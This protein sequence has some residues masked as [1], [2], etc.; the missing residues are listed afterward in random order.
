MPRIRKVKFVWGSTAR[1][2][3]YRSLG[4]WLVDAR[5][6]DARIKGVVV[7]V[8]ALL[9]WAVALVAVVYVAGTMQWYAIQ[10]RRVHCSVTRADALLL[11]LRWAQ[12]REK[13]GRDMIAQG[14]DDL[15]AHRW[16]E[17]Q[18]ELRTGLARA[19]HDPRARLELAQIYVIS[20][21]RP[22]ALTLLTEDLA[23]GYPG[24]AFLEGLFR[25]AND[26]EDFA[27][28]L[29]ACDRFL[30][31]VPA[32]DRTWLLTEKLRALLAAGRDT[33][34]I[35]Q[36]DAEGEA[37]V[38]DVREARVL[39]LLHLGRRAEALAFLGTWLSRPGAN[40][41]Q[42]LRLKAQ[43]LRE[44]GRIEEM[45]TTLA[46]LCALAPDEP[47][48]AVYA[49]V[50]QMRAG[51]T[52]EATARLDDY[53]WRF[54]AM[55]ANLSLAAAELGEIDALPLVRRCEEEAE[56]H[57]FPAQPF[58]QLLLD[59]QV[60]AGDWVAAARTVARLA[61]LTDHAAPADRF[62]FVWMQHL[63]AATGPDDGLRVSLLE[64]IRDRPLPL[65]LFRR[66]AEAM[67]M[68]RRAETASAVCAIALRLYPHSA[69]LHEIDRRAQVLAAT[70]VPVTTVVVAPVEPVP[71][72]EEFFRQVETLTTAGRWE[73]AADLVRKVR[74]FKPAWVTRREAAVLDWDLRIALKQD[75]VP[76]LLSAAR[77]YLNGSRVRADRVLALATETRR[78]GATEHATLLLNE[79]LRR[80]PDY[81]PAQELRTQ[82]QPKA[83]TKS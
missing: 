38:G 20:G 64:S 66:T 72:E 13:T 40:R 34:V 15:R 37:A 67:L 26:G 27:V 41:V 82:W 77:L 79:V 36:A 25:I 78:N 43:A 50:Q 1:Y 22:F 52:A 46:E 63:V 54:G 65:R 11:P 45:D 81:A 7:N 5:T 29:A 49:L 69:A 60:A 55:A 75:D 21:R 12:V 48:L 47:R 17:G 80:L 33:E 42:V 70:Q 62:Y 44:A 6:T 19:P 76:E 2:P 51:R 59:A 28:T 14:L 16:G 24:R 71:A 53:L 68:A 8:R 83:A 10:R 31:H 57:G 23:Y 9:W 4:L 35:A 18:L 32:G 74:A 30:P 39:A 58:L 61:P 3:D 73:E 56:A